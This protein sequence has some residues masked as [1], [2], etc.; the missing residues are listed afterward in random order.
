MPM[1]KKSAKKKR[2][3]DNTHNAGV[4][5]VAAAARRSEVSTAKECYRKVVRIYVKHFKGRFIINHLWEFRVM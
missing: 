2:C 5:E 4:R 1:R 3:L